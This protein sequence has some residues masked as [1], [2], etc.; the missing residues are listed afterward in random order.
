MSI[1]YIADVNKFCN[2]L[3]FVILFYFNVLLFK[4]EFKS[5]P[6]GELKFMKFLHLLLLS[7]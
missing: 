6:F 1:L 3:L 7:A 4:Q 5:G 2:L